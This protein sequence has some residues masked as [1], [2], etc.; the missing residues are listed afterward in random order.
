MQALA[1]WVPVRHFVFAAFICAV[2]RVEENREPSA[3]S[4]GKDFR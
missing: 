3:W 1:F 4:S 2:G